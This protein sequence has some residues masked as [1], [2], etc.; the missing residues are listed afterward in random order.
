MRSQAIVHWI[1]SVTLAVIMLGG[2]LLALNQVP[3]GQSRAL[4]NDYTIGGIC[5]ATIQACINNPIVQAGDRILIP[6]GR[7][8]ESLTLNK[9]VSLLG[10]GAS[11]AVIHAVAGQRVLTITGN[12]ITATTV[13]SGLTF[14]G[15]DNDHIY[16]CF[17]GCGGGVLVANQ[18]QPSIQYVVITNNS[19]FDGGGIYADFNTPLILQHVLLSNNV[20]SDGDGGAVCAG[21]SLV[22]ID[23]DVISNTAYR[24]GGGM[25][26]SGDLVLNGGQIARNRSLVGFGGGFTAGSLSLTA[27]MV[28]SNAGSQGGGGANV[29]GAVSLNGGAFINNRIVAAGSGGGLWAIGPLEMRDTEFISN[30]S[31]GFGGGI[32]VNNN[33]AAIA[34]GWFERNVSRS[35]GGGLRVYGPVTL[36]DTVFVSNTGAGGGGLFANNGATIDRGSFIGNQGGILAG[37]G[38]GLTAYNT[39]HIRDTVFV[40]NSA[41]DV[42]GAIKYGHDQYNVPGT[43][44]IINTL[45]ARNIAGKQGNALYQSSGEVIILHATIVDTGLNP[46]QAIVVMSGTAGIT[47]TIITNHAIAISQTDG[48]VYQ[49]YNLFSGN[50]VTQTGM[51]IDGGHSLNGDPHFVN[52]DLDNY[53]LLS[54]SAAIDVGVD[55]GVLSD[56]DG[57]P[58]PL[59]AGFDIGAYEYPDFSNH[60]YLPFVVKNH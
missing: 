58:R 34:G 9:G 10:A 3:I 55:A 43:G 52:P 2:W 16:G 12:L 7:Y 18:A 51:V 33:G 45:F 37:T 19:A 28:M 23:T 8:T 24:N 60:V 17:T 54:P 15:G 41:V 35:V 13:I 49:D 27:T 20:S 40:N 42:G 4:S 1:L 56:L 5:G 26:V 31:V 21:N 57:L 48:T 22:L 6:A 25:A 46:R 53:H 47:N 32:D 59:G 38:G 50:T 44:Q 36:Q 11:T 14:T 30:T 39:L 29:S